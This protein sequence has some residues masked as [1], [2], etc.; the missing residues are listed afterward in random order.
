MALVRGLAHA[1]AT[2]HIIVG[3]HT[4][5]FVDQYKKLKEKGGW[6]AV[7]AA[8]YTRTVGIWAVPTPRRL[9]HC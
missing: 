6:A 5:V 7:C 8:L 3:S 9:V 1:A 4:F 2:G